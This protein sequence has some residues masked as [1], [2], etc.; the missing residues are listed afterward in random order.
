MWCAR[1]CYENDAIYTLDGYYL[2][3]YARQPARGPCW[4]DRG[5]RLGAIWAHLGAMLAYLGPSWGYVGLSWGQFGP[6]LGLCWPILTH[7]RARL[8]HLGAMLAH[9]AAYVGPTLT[10]KIRKM[11]TAKNT[12]KRGSFWGRRQARRPLST[13]ERREGLRQCHGQLRGPLE[14]CWPSLGLCWPTWRARLEWWTCLGLCGPI[15]WLCWP[16][17]PI[18][19]VM[20]PHLEAMLVHLDTYVGPCWPILS[21]KLRK[22]GK[23]RNSKKHCKTRDF[24]GAFG[25]RRSVSGRG[26]GPSLLRRGESCRT[27]MPRPAPGPCRAP[28]RIKL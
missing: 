5:E 9:L 15:L 11:G 17:W 6:I 1:W 4:G 16:M 12:V 20:L 3:A 28:G 19:G 13:S 25:G 8:A 26:G 23:N 2:S 24:L 7:L 14:L 10:H 18:L 22:M 27:A 21:H